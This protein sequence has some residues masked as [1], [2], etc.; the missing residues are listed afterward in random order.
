MAVWIAC[1]GEWAAAVPS[2]RRGN[3]F[4]LPGVQLPSAFTPGEKIA[5]MFYWTL[6]PAPLI[7]DN[8]ILTKAHPVTFM[9]SQW[10]AAIHSRWPLH[11][12]HRPHWS[13][14]EH[15]MA[16]SQSGLISLLPSLHCNS[17]SLHW[18]NL[19]SLP[20]TSLVLIEDKARHR[21]IVYSWFPFTVEVHGEPPPRVSY[22][23][24]HFGKH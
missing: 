11:Q 21:I 9:F 22:V 12:P 5:L 23:R 16:R 3:L 14:G 7:L 20:F 6:P 10:G 2:A 19:S 13:F 15:L 18:N 24:V 17:L 8:L 1:R 4:G